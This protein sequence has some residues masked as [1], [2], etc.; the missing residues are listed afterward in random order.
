MSRLQF[1]EG[2][3]EKTRRYMD[4]YLSSELLVETNHELLRHLDS[5][6]SC[7]AELETRTRLRAR[8]KLAVQA[9]PVPAEMPALVRARLRK[10][11]SPVWMAAGWTMAAAAAILFVIFW[12]RPQANQT[13]YIERISATVAPVYQPGLCDHIHCSVFR[14]YPANP[15]TVAEMESKL[16]AEYRGL[17]PL[18]SP[19][20]PAG[21][22]VVLA[23]RCKYQGREFVHLTMRKGEDVLSLVVAR[24][25]QGEAL[26]ALSSAMVASGVPIYHAATDRYQVAAF[27]NDRA[28]AYVVGD[29]D[30]AA[31]LQVAASIAPGVLGLL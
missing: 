20:V 30:R 11:Q 16:G 6:P 27:E 3:C 26:A 14:R 15:P 29:L 4:A 18:V 23:H 2:A 22:R 19:A 9:Q 8:L 7:T 24:K 12:I 25:R 5:C 21:Y 31:T 13:A 28:L 1:G 17:L 10:R